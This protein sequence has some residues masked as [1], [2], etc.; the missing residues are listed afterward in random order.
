[1]QGYPFDRA[2]VVGYDDDRLAWFMGQLPPRL[3]ACTTRLPGIPATEVNTAAWAMQGLYSA[4]AAHRAAFCGDPSFAELH[5]LPLTAQQ[6]ADY[7]SQRR[8]WQLMVDEAILVALVLQEDALVTEVEE[9]QLLQL[10]TE[11]PRAGEW[12]LVYLGAPWRPPMEPVPGTSLGVPAVYGSAQSLRAYLLTLP[13]ARKLLGGSLPALFPVEVYVA[14]QTRAG[15][16]ALQTPDAI[17]G[18]RA[19]PGPSS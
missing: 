11:V 3:R 16:R 1:M 9:A 4:N 18:A 6:L 14:A 2:L 19:E 5:P 10:A 15:L 13:G 12:D 8:A 7:D 17:I